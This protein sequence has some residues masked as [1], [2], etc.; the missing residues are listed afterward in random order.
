[1]QYH[2]SLLQSVTEGIK[3]RTKQ[4]IL[5]YNGINTYVEILL[6]VFSER[7]GKYFLPQQNAH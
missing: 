2:D 1:M 6:Y 3:I 5:M 4:N 7:R